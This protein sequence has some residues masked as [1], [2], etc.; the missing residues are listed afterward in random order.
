MYLGTC[1]SPLVGSSHCW[2]LRRRTTNNS[3]R[4]KGAAKERHSRPSPAAQTQSAATGDLRVTGL[5]LPTDA[6]AGRAGCAC[7]GPL[8]GL[9][10]L[11]NRLPALSC[12]F[13]A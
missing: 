11:H 9:S 5:A 12:N 6:D 3:S 1:P 4:I 2:A 8:L 13:F 10:K 7:A